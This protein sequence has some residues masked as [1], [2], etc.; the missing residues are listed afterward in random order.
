MAFRLLY[1]QLNKAEVVTPSNQDR[2]VE[3][4]RSIAELMIWGDQHDEKFFLYF[5]EKGILRFFLDIL[6]QNPSSKIKIQILQTLSILVQNIS[7]DRSLFYLLSNNF[8]ND[9]I[10]H[11]FDFGDDSLVDHYMAFLKTLSLKLDKNT[12]HFLFN[13]QANG[14]LLVHFDWSRV[15]FLLRIFF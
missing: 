13:E 5:C 14:I 8:V 10:V 12:L 11:G 1:S 6:N 15:H 7:N 9:L 3:I 2:V 4:L